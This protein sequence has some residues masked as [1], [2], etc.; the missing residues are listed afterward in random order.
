ML[1]V[2]LTAAREAGAA[3]LEGSRA[4]IQVDREYHH[5]VKL[6]MDK[7]AEGIIVGR[8]RAAF[9]DHAILSEECGRL[10]GAAEYEWVI[11]PLDG[12]YNFFKR[13]PCWATSIALRRKGEPVLGVI[14]DPTRDEMFHAEQGKGVF[15]NGAPIRCSDVSDLRKATL[16][17]A[18]T[19]T[20]AWRERNRETMTRLA[21]EAAKTRA[22]GSAALHI[23]YVACGRLDIYYEYGIWPWDVS[24]GMVMVREAGGKVSSR[25]HADGSMTVLASAAGVHEAADHVVKV[26]EA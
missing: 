11:D 8:L 15:L 13:I 26:A 18:V 20:E 14:Y 21:R 7:K 25:S 9:P 24:A 10:A 4:A 2:A 1:N 19:Q 22:L 3:L 6:A 17:V 12:T 23:A 5:D 16:A